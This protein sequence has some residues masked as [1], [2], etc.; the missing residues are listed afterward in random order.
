MK[1]TDAQTGEL[2]AA[3]GWAKRGMALSAAAQWKWLTLKMPWTF[4]PTGLL[5]VVIQTDTKE[6]LEHFTLTRRFC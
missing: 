6:D 2:L 1:A 4:G 3:A 5:A